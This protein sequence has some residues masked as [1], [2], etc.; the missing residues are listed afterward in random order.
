[1]FGDG[2]WLDDRTNAQLRRYQNWLS[3]INTGNLVIVEIGAGTAVPTV[4]YECEQFSNA[5]LVRINPREFDVPA[6]GIAIAQGGL[7]ALQEIEN[8]C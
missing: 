3:S 8:H 4:R 2:Y 7:A 5:T 6:G 1:M